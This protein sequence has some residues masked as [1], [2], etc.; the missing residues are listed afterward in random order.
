MK[1]TY[2]QI[3]SKDFSRALGK[4]ATYGGF[5]D[6]KELAN[7]KAILKQFEKCVDMAQKEWIVELKKW[8]MLDEKG[9]FVPDERGPG[10]FKIPIE[11]KAAF[12]E[13]EKMFDEQALTIWADT[14]PFETVKTV[15]L[16]AMDLLQMEGIIK[17]PEQMD[18]VM[19]PEP[20]KVSA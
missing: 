5:T 16:S 19:T 9:E 17:E 11:K 18:A 8:A 7:I 2:K 20:Q 13:V 10:T 12:E 4:L 14:I 1:I 6:Y 3:K 15:G